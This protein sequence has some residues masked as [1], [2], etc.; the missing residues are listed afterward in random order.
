MDKTWHIYLRWLHDRRRS[1]IVWSLSIAAVS[2][3]TAAFFESLGQTAGQNTD[4]G[5]AASSI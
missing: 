1:T 5:S 2:V 4:S 3:V